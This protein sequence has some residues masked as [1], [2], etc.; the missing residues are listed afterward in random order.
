[1]F[2]IEHHIFSAD[3]QILP[4]AISGTAGTPEIFCICAEVN[5]RI[6]N[7]S[8][9]AS[10]ITA[11]LGIELVAKDGDLILTSGIIVIFVIDYDV[12]DIIYVNTLLRQVGK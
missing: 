8:S 5:D 2:G 11:M 9:F 7:T 12:A 1:M 4:L 3:R 10:D 6:S